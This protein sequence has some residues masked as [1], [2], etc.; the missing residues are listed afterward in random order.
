M[1]NIR[2][3]KAQIA[4][5]RDEIMAEAEAKIGAQTQ[6]LT[7]ALEDACLALY[8]ETGKIA[9]V[10]REYGTKDF[11]TVK[12]ILTRAEARAALLA[13]S[14]PTSPEPSERFTVT[15]AGQRED[16]APM[17]TVTDTETGAHVTVA[18]P[19]RTGVPITSGALDPQ[20]KLPADERPMDLYHSLRDANSPA[21]EAL[22]RYRSVTNKD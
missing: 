15:E 6:A 18:V 2:S 3:I 8:R 10:Q 1:S 4:S 16:G 12:E 5:V 13:P 19:A 20:W 7:V 17:Y 21:R 9:A 11:R 14:A 22:D